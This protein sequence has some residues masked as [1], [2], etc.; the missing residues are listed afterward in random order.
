MKEFIIIVAL[1]CFCEDYIVAQDLI[2]GQGN[3][4]G[5]TITSSHQVS[6]KNADNTVSSKGFKPNLN[7][8]SRFLSQATFGVDYS[9]I[10]GL[11]DEGFEQWIDDQLDMPVGEPIMTTVVEQKNAKNIANEDPDGGAFNFHWHNGWW[12]YHFA[13]EDHLRQRLAFAL[14][15]LFVISRFSS[16][17]DNAYALA[18]YY[19][20]LLSNAFGNYRTLLDSVTYHSAMGEYLT[21]MNNS[22]TDTIYEFDWSV[23]PPDTLDTQYTFPDENYAREVMQLFSIG[24]FELNEDGSHKMDPHGNDIPTYDNMDIAELAKIFTGFSYYD[25]NHFGHGPNHWEETFLHPMQIYDEYHEYGVKYMLDSSIVNNTGPNRAHQDVA[26]ALDFLF[27]HDNVGPFIGKF[28]IQRFVTSNPSPD[29]VSRVTDAFNGDGPYG[30]ERGDMKALM[31]AILLDEEARS[32]SV[33]DDPNVGKLREPFVRYMQLGKSFYPTSV[34]GEFRNTMFDIYDFIEQMPLSS[35]SVFNFFQSDFQPIGAINEA[36]KVAPEF[37]IANTQSIAG[38]INGLNEWIMD[39][40]YTRV[41]RLYED[42]P[43]VEDHYMNFDYSTELALTTDELVP[44]LIERLNVTLAHGKLE[45]GTIDIIVD[46]VRN[47]EVD[48]WPG[49]LEPLYKVKLA[50]NLIMIS[51]DYLINR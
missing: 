16:F 11:I 9:Q 46:A 25:S 13:N 12:N 38:Y 22:R 19:D 50:I 34:S 3:D 18:S 4:Q 45:Q 15:E 33:G 30:T 28:L 17:G 44:Q 21:F 43:N 8:S 41:W 49:G 36:D 32:C 42:E 40:G 10:E 39:N 2:L 1:L 26:D 37:Q 31:K 6:G 7:S 29:Y 35:P 27:N 5:I 48:I 14:S 20:M 24:L 47:F 51:P 23:W